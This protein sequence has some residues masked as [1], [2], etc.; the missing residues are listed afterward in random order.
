[1]IMTNLTK[2]ALSNLSKLLPAACRVCLGLALLFLLFPA[3]G[4]EIAQNVRFRHLTVNDGLSQDSVYQVLQDNYGFVWFATSEGLNRYDGNE[5]VTYLHDPKKEQSLSKDW[6]WSMLESSD[7]RLWVGTD[8][9]GLN[10]LNQDGRSFEHFKHDPGDE[11]SISGNIVRTI[12][13]DSAAD[14]WLGTDSGLNR[15][16]METGIF[17]RF[18]ADDNNP[19][20]LSSNKIR[21]VLQEQHGTLWIGTDGGGL[22]QMDIGRKTVRHF[23]HDPQDENSIS[24][25]RIRALFESM[26]GMLWIGTYDQGLNRYNPRTGFVKRYHIDSGHGLTSNLIRDIMQDHRGVLWLATDNGLFEYRSESDTFLG[27]HKEASNSNSLTDDR[28]ISLFQDE[29]KVLWVGTHAGIN[30]WNYQTT[31]FEL[32]RQSSTNHEGLRSNTVL[33]FTQSDDDTIWVGTYAGLEKFSQQSGKFQH[34][35]KE[36]GLVD[37]RIT[38]LTAENNHLWIGTFASGLMRMDLTTGEL[39]HYP[40][41]DSRDNWLKKGGIT[42]LS[43]DNEGDLWVASYGGGLFRYNKASDDFTVFRHREGDA[44]SLANNKVVYV[45]SSRSGTIWVSLFGGGIAKLNPKSGHF[46]HYQHDPSNP[47]SISSNENWTMM[48]D[49]QGNLWIGS[50][51]NGVNK[52]TSAESKK[53]QAAFSH[54]SRVDG[55]KS[56]AIYGILEDSKGD[57]W[58]SSNRGITK[59]SPQ[60]NVLQHYGPHH[61]LQSFEFNSGAHFKARSG[62]MF[63]GGSNGFN[64]FYPT[65]ILR[66]Q[67]PP[68]VALTKIIK[69]NSTMQGEVATH[70]LESLTLNAHEYSVSFEF[71]ALDFA[72]VEDNRYRYKLDGYDND[73]INPDKVHRATYTNLPSGQ[74]SFKVEA[75]NNDGVWNQDA[76]QL[77]VTVLPPWYRTKIAYLGYF[78]LFMLF[79]SLLYLVHLHRLKK[80]AIN[81][82]ELKLKVEEKTQELRQR[83][84]QLEERNEELKSANK[85]LA[86]VCITDIGTGLHNRRFVVDYMSK[87]SK[88]LERRL[89]K[90]T[91]TETIAKNRPIFFVV[92]EIDDFFQINEAHGYGTG[93]AVMLSVS[94]QVSKKCRQGDVLARWGEGSFLVAGETDDIEAI[95]LLAKRLISTIESHNIVLKAESISVTAS[96]GIS[97]FPFSITQPSLFTWEQ[98][99]SIA[100]S[101]IKL[102]REKGDGTWSCIRAGQLGLSRGD[103]RKILSEPKNMAEKE[104]ISLLYDVQAADDLLITDTRSSK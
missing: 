21:A 103:Y 77:K 15:Y 81:S 32:F 1:M 61:G 50:Q 100:E 75:A 94:R 35:G 24:S 27:Y 65:E 57:I 12:F 31:S 91:L 39:K 76:M 20:S 36:N 93:D 97:Y 98:V 13:E 85:Q 45:L 66:N 22:N 101:A 11:N 88:N 3:W 28:V 7:G 47:D 19:M 6:I 90:M 87:I 23:R 33:T 71:A 41:D 69:I 73:W 9:G 104:V 43:V 17:E 96:A 51:G 16:N 53:Q 26:D 54:I 40:P 58:F 64:A 79:L 56:N 37:E 25:D 59:F 49:K 48:E 95:L 30:L 14:L 86:E 83:S 2:P 89:E 44:N 67:H 38:A 42:R 72:V 68:K 62:K 46:I 102:A 18:V 84:S 29:G 70:L 52:L 55:L 78:I 92:F 80:E 34:Y 63:F 74:Y 8:G 5:F 82:R 10:L 99:V 4:S 60:S